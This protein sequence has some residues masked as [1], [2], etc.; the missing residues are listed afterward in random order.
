LP[1]DPF[2][3]LLQRYLE[4]VRGMGG[5][6][7]FEEVVDWASREGLGSAVV[8]AVVLNELVA[9]GL[10]KAPEGL[11]EVEGVRDLKAPVIVETPL[12]TEPSVEEKAVE[13]PP[14]QPAPIPVA[15]VEGVRT[16][17]E[18][19]DEDLKAAIAYLN[20]YWS[21][22]ELRFIDDL[23]MMGVRDP[24]K[25]LRRLLELGFAERT[26]SGVVNATSKLPRVKRKGPLLA[27]FL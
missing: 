9:R 4:A 10:L 18:V 19:G 20:D 3:R 6:A 21:V 14:Q 2:E 15:K 5:R 25:V 1:E 17:V 16:E 24:P 12:P 22:G 7:S 8:A 11:K 26:P 13:A 23:R 27:D